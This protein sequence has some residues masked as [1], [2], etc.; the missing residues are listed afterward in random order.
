MDVSSAKGEQEVGD[1]ED[2][3]EGGSRPQAQ[4]SLD[5]PSA[6][7][8][9][10]QEKSEKKYKKW[11]KLFFSRIGFR[12]FSKKGRLVSKATSTTDLPQKAGAA[13]TPSHVNQ[14]RET[15]P[16]KNIFRYSTSDKLPPYYRLL[17]D[18][19]LSDSSP[20]RGFPSQEPP[21]WGSP[22]SYSQEVLRRAGEAQSSQSPNGEDSPDLNEIH[23]RRKRPDG[24]RSS[25]GKESF[26]QRKSPKEEES[27][28]RKRQVDR[29]KLLD[30]KRRPRE[31]KRP[32]AR[33]R[34]LDKSRSA[35]KERPADKQRL[36]ER[37]RSAKQ[38]KL[39]DK[40]ELVI[41]KR[42]PDKQ[43]SPVKKRP[44]DRRSRKDASPEGRESD[45]KRESQSQGKSKSAPA[46]YEYSWSRSPEKKQHKAAVRGSLISSTTLLCCCL[47][48][49]IV[50]FALVHSFPS[51]LGSVNWTT[52][53]RKTYPPQLF[54]MIVLVISALCIVCLVRR[55]VS[56]TTELI[57]SL[58][59]CLLNA[60]LV[61]LVRFGVFTQFPW[62]SALAIPLVVL[63]SFFMLCG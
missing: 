47:L 62:L 14:Q 35:G 15:L 33:E 38:R 17:I 55:A 61:D 16:T 53:P 39:P 32:P 56:I 58:T 49:G 29:E 9:A 10:K 37:K 28:G 40:N 6:A 23:E 46:V 21:G 60:S 31:G 25:D 24:E 18:S 45:K 22:R 48:V 41:K 3:E 43:T 7:P 34:L 50:V 20:P 51:S 4:P 63:L 44:A 1:G 27:P 57:V 59:L 26:D 12:F 42:L 30:R 2:D 52:L 13:P 11:F 5:P 19:P 54:K 8:T 36:P